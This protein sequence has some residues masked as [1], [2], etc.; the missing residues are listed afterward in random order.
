MDHPIGHRILECLQEVHALRVHRLAS[1][2]LQ[3]RATALKRYQQE[4]FRRSYQDLA[5]QPRYEPATRFFLEQL[6]GPGDF[7]HRDAQFARI[8]P[9]LVRLFPEQVVATVR[10]LAE[11]HAMTERLDSTM[12]QHLPSDA[13]SAVDYVRAWQATGEVSSRGRQI[14]VVLD[15]G[16]DLDAFTHRPLLMTSLRVMRGPARAAGLQDLQH[17]LESGLGAFR[18]MHGAHGFL[19]TIARRERA[20]CARLF[21]G[22]AMERLVAGVT[23]DDPLGQLP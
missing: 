20:L 21:E 1:P 22:E 17:F 16:R 12:A 15:I 18:H 5:A 14:D 6:Y 23:G 3:A 19:D 10:E 8:V 4:R 11:L 9:K 2:D 7:T 13:I